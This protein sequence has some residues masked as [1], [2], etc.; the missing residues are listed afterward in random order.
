MERYRGCEGIYINALKMLGVHKTL[1]IL[2]CPIRHNLHNFSR[3][4]KAHKTQ[5]TIMP[6]FNF[7][8]IGL[9]YV[10]PRINFK[11][12]ITLLFS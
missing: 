4:T 7:H 8:V 9:V 5:I 10:D 2:C 12:S 1:S 3:L 6:Y 11:M